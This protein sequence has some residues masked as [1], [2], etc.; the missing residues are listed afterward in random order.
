MKQMWRWRHSI[1][2]A[3]LLLLWA[4]PD[5]A[6]AVE[7]HESNAHESDTIVLH[8]DDLVSVLKERNGTRVAV[9][10]TALAAMPLVLRE[11]VEQ[12]LGGERATIAGSM[13]RDLIRLGQV[14]HFYKTEIGI[15]AAFEV[16]TDSPTDAPRRNQLCAL[17]GFGKEAK[18]DS[19][20]VAESVL[21]RHGF[22]YLPYLALLLR[23]ETI[24]CLAADFK[25]T[26]S[27]T[28]ALLDRTTQRYRREQK[29]ADVTLFIL[30]ATTM[31]LLLVTGRKLRQRVK[32][33]LMRQRAAYVQPTTTLVALELDAAIPPTDP[34][35]WIGPTPPTNH[36][37]TTR[38]EDRRYAQDVA[39]AIAK[40]LRDA[41]GAF[42]QAALN[43]LLTEAQAEFRRPH[44]RRHKMERLLELAQ[45]AAE[46]TIGVEVDDDATTMPDDRSTSAPLVYYQH[47]SDLLLANVP[48]DELVPSENQHCARRIIWIL[49][50]NGTHPYVG[51]HCM[52]RSFFD[53]LHIKFGEATVD[54]VFKTLLACGIIIHRQEIG[55]NQ[56]RCSL[57]TPAEAKA[58]GEEA[59]RT[60]GALTRIML[61]LQG[62]AK[63]NGQH[64]Q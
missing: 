15:V 59:A 37:E 62:G 26:E 29:L 61:G 14:I 51:E 32:Q 47:P 35:A 38:D 55:R 44:I 60:I 63:L 58:R 52:P 3:I 64:R 22:R 28:L 40:L 9:E 43:E 41:T 45:K 4:W 30:V 5:R 13:E 20:G 50:N 8:F 18:C 2:A 27:E 49:L 48:L 56:L 21:H 12:A 36:G 46:A 11:A 24:A 57:A 19:F 23:C 53:L 33:W 17:G 7:P 42:V 39:A 1:V 10:T 31:F 34:P 6:L 25:M 16:A 54:A